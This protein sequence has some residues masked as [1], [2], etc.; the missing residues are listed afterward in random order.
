M[1]NTKL[2]SN[3]EDMVVHLE[4]KPI[5]AASG[6]GTDLS[7]MRLYQKPLESHLDLRKEVRVRGA[8]VEAS[9]RGR[10]EATCTEGRVGRGLRVG[11]RAI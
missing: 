10:M 3:L 11:Q 5:L 8:A 1:R 7:N 6:T 9:S 4:P 2:L